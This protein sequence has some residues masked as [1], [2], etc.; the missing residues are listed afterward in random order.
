[1]QGKSGREKPGD[2]RTM[3]TRMEREKRL[4]A[5]YIKKRA[6]AKAVRLV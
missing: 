3:T 2:N 4:E 1:M 5:F 6:W